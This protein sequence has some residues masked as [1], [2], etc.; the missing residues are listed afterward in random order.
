MSE[1]YKPRDLYRQAR[2][3]RVRNPDR[4]SARF[5]P[6]PRQ[7]VVYRDG[8]P[9]ILQPLLCRLHNQPWQTCAACGPVRKR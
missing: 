3:D 4:Y 6:E 1:R 7:Q 2:E 9:T 8:K 5:E